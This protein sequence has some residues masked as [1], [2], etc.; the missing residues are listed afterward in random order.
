MGTTHFSGLNLKAAISAAAD[1][2]ASTGA[3]SIVGIATDDTLLALTA[4][5]SGTSGTLTGANIAVS[6]ASISAANTVTLAGTA[7]YSGYAIQVLYLD[8][9][10]T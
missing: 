2:P 7:A 10:A 6:A 8:K 3:M 9:D 1:G 5:K 4:F